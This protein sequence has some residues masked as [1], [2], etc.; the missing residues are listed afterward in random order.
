MP[1]AAPT[2]E[3][4]WAPLRPRSRPQTGT[5][6]QA[7]AAYVFSSGYVLLLLVFCFL[8]MVFALYL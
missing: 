3:R 1:T 5:R 2:K 4:R 7:F 8:P 6:A